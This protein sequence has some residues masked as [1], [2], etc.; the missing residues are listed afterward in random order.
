MTRAECEAKLIELMEQMV[1]ILHEYNP[2]CD[3]LS[4]AYSTPQG[5]PHISIHNSAFAEAGSIG[6]FKSGDGP[7]YSYTDFM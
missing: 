3:F 6:C 4:C 7:L 1:A 5:K 2:E